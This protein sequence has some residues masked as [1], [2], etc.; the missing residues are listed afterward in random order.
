MKE[1]HFADGAGMSARRNGVIAVVFAVVFAVTAGI[2]ADAWSRGDPEPL[3]Y[4]ATLVNGNVVGS[5][6]MMAEGLAVT[7][8]H[9]VRGLHVGGTVMM[10]SSSGKR[11][12]FQGRLVAVSR[13]M[14]MA[15]VAVPSGRLAV[16]ARGDAAPR[17]GQRVVSAGVD[18]TGG[19]PAPRLEVSGVVTQAS[20][21]QPAFGPGLVARL[22]GV[23]PGFSGGPLFDGEGRLLG[24]VT[25]IRPARGVAR[26]ASGFA[27]RQGIAR[28]VTEAYVLSA[29]AI[30][31]EARR[32]LR[33]AER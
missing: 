3:D 11:E 12:R 8:A 22:P 27:P 1:W 26:P 25:A 24:M 10:V 15:L 17:A 19:W 6:F 5:T 20:V 14:D 28:D 33:N 30:R 7:N 16:S 9:V 31:A 29:G 13:E 32:L 2:R 21:D 4:H 18:A 23:K